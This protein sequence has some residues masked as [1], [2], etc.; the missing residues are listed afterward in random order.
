MRTNL[1]LKYLEKYKTIHLVLYNG[2]LY[3]PK[4]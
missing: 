4:W 3:E 1:A 2:F